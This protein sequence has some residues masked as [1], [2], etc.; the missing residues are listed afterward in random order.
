LFVQA[1]YDN[2]LKPEL[3]K[4]MG[5]FLPNLTRC[6][7]DASHWA[8][9]QKPEEVNAI[10]RNWLEKQGFTVKSSL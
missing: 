6:E 3:S 1:N 10:V 5:E 9:T 7:V 4:N 8:L 2:V